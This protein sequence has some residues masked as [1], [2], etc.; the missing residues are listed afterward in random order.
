MNKCVFLDR[1]GV[2]NVDNPAYTFLTTRFHII[3]GVPQALYE[4]REAGY[5]LIVV[6]NQSGIS[7]KLYTR[8][9]MELCHIYLQDACDHVI[10]HFYFSP[11]HETVTNSLTKKPGSLLF[12]KAIARYNIDVKKSWMIG[13]R[14][15]DL[16][17]AKK[18]GVKTIQI[19]DECVDELGDYKVD[20]LIGA[21]NLIRGF[22]TFKTTK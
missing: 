9:Q 8:R 2:L 10:D 5:L 6:T 15:R 7:R 11:Y 12:E 14:S 20:D 4:M 1:D 13:D 19:G 16:T 22:A 18:L 17:P 3:P 21:S